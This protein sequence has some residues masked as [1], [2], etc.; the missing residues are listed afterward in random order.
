MV[1]AAAAEAVTANP[2]MVIG[3]VPTQNA[4]TP[5]SPGEMNV[6]G[7]ETINQQEQE[8]SFNNFHLF[9]LFLIT[10]FPYLQ[11]QVPKLY[12]SFALGKNTPIF[13]FDY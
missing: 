13:L 7:A 11:I 2:E 8:V 10:M 1:V 9:N 3:N 5:T 6:T 12:S 4:L